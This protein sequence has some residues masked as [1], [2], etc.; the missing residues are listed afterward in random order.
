MQSSFYPTTKQAPLWI[1][2]T[3]LRPDVC[4]KL[5]FNTCCRL[6]DV[7][8][9]GYFKFM[10]DWIRQNSALTHRATLGNMAI[11]SKKLHYS[12]LVDYAEEMKIHQ[13]RYLSIP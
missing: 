12:F 7:A 6:W 11:S 4:C 2:V 13:V 3:V 9:T 10:C 5:P 1:T 8:C